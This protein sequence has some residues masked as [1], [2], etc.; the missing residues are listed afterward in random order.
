MTKTKKKYGGYYFAKRRGGGRE[1]LSVRNS[2]GRTNCNFL[3]E[4][5]SREIVELIGEDFLEI[6]VSKK[7]VENTLLGREKKILGI[8]Y[9]KATQKRG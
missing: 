3:N 6:A 9:E 8:V 7:R 5:D 4:S 1:G 2:E